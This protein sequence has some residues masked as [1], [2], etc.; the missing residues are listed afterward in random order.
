[1]FILLIKFKVNCHFSSYSI[2]QYNINIFSD[3]KLCFYRKIVFF[4]I[5]RIYQVNLWYLLIEL[6]IN[7][8][9]AASSVLFLNRQCY[10]I[11]SPPRRFLINFGFGVSYTAGGVWIYWYTVYI[12]ILSTTTFFNLAISRKMSPV[13]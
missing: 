2:N 1:M 4:H 13:L 3:R 6:I 11:V 8:L 10:A 9:I 12:Y 5:D 7:F